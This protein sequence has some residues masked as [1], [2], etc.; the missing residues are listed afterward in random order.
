MALVVQFGARNSAAEK[1]SGGQLCVR[2]P[3]PRPL[4]CESGRQQRRRIGCDCESHPLCGRRRPEVER[5]SRNKNEN[6]NPRSKLISRSNQNEHI[7]T[8]TRAAANRHLSRAARFDLISTDPDELNGKM[9]RHFGVDSIAT[10]YEYECARS[11]WVR[12]EQR[13]SDVRSASE[14]DESFVGGLC[15]GRGGKTTTTT[16]NSVFT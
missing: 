15:F 1:P 3:P 12:L 4:T 7:A 13:K 16:T 8:T 10:E 11:H 14:G 9:E 2:L 5:E 6:L